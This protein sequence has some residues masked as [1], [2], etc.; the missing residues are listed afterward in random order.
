MCPHF[1]KC[2]NDI[3]GKGGR[4]EATGLSGIAYATIHPSPTFLAQPL[5][6]CQPVRDE[7]AISRG[8]E[9][10]VRVL[11]YLVVGTTIVVHKHRYNKQ[12]SR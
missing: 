4:E 7:S 10:R 2:R 9:N 12:S 3:A 5:A 6:A 11:T 1:F 8:G